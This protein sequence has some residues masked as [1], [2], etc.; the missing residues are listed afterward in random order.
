MINIAK[1]IIQNKC[2]QNREE[3][4]IITPCMAKRLF[5][6][7]LA[8]LVGSGACLAKSKVKPL[9]DGFSLEGVD[10]NV[11]KDVNGW[12]FVPLAAMADDQGIVKAKAKL[13][14]LPSSGLERLIQQKTSGDGDSFRLW[15]TVTRYEDENFVFAAYFLPITEA[16]ETATRLEDVKIAG[17]NEPDIIPEDVMEMLRPKRVVNLARLKKGPGTEQD[18]IIADR[19]GF[20]RK[21]SDGFVFVFDALGRNVDTTSFPL[22][23]CGVL[24]MMWE[25]QQSSAWDVRYKIVGIMTKYQGSHYL[26]P[27]RA[28]RIYSHG[29]FRR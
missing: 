3:L 23:K 12:L 14:I 21:S 19:T 28:T 2:F 10:G 5:I 15:G 11:V 8:V 20:V 26:L 18:G 25:K 6:I 24:E 27:E 17:P 13:R 9:R 4:T 1:N 29:N 16:N 7:L 22:L